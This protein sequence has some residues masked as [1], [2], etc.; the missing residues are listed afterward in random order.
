MMEA[1]G[2]LVVASLLVGVVYLFVTRGGCEACDAW[3]VGAI[4]RG[5]QGQFEECERM[6]RALGDER[7]CSDLL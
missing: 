5:K 6:R 1:M 3:V 2:R 7:D 4:G